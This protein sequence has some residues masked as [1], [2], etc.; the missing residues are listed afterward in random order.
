MR[1]G[2]VSPIVRTRLGF[3]II[4]LLEIK[5]S[6]QMSFEEAEPEISFALENERRRQG[7]AMIAAEL[8]NRA[9]FVRFP[10]RI[11]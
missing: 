11:D 7:C 6:R 4:Q 10:S 2:E 5:A 8:S 9:D 1:A 3:H